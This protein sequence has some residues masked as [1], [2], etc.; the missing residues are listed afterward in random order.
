MLK[1]RLPIFGFTL[2]QWLNSRTNSFESQA[3]KGSV[4]AV[5]INTITT[6][7]PIFVIIL[8]GWLARV[9]GF[10][11]TEF[12]EAAN[13]LVFYLAIPAMFFRSIS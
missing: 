10:M 4:G 6:I 13:R 8:L 9:F 7:V 2:E 12:I 5:M 11:R 3:N 1:W